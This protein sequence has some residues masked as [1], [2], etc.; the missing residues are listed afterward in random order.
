VR[1]N[2]ESI[3]WLTAEDRAKIFHKNAEQV[4]TRFKQ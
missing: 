3:P 4:F 2:I 1:P